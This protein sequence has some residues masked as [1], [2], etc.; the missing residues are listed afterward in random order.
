MIPNIQIFFTIVIASLEN[1]RKILKPTLRELA[2]IW[3]PRFR[4]SAIGPLEAIG[5]AYYEIIKQI[6]I[7]KKIMIY[8]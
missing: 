3:Y 2:E 6:H 5:N 8:T 4:F 7:K 1:I